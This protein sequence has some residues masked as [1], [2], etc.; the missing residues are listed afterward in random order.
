[1]ICRYPAVHITTCKQTQKHEQ[2][3]KIDRN[4][5]QNIIFWITDEERFIPKNISLLASPSHFFPERKW[6]MLMWSGGTVIK[7]KKV[8]NKSDYIFFF[9][10]EVHRRDAK[11]SS[12]FFALSQ[13]IFFFCVCVWRLTN[14][15]VKK[16]KLFFWS[17][18]LVCFWGMKISQLLGPWPFL[19]H[20]PKPLRTLTVIA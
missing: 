17:P 10:S 8:R 7:G 9:S 2:Q 4:I 14:V 3:G 19:F 12:V 11:F 5:S 6:S 18:V 16:N 1:M 20:T 13:I 15:I